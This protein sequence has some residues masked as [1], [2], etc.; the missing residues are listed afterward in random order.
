MRALIFAAGRGERLRPY[1]D[2]LAKP[3]I[4]FLNIPI[5]AFPLFYLEQAGLQEL[6]VNTHHLPETVEQTLKNLVPKKVSLKFSHETPLIL[7]SGGGLAQA[8]RQFAS[9]TKEI[10]VANGDAVALF[11]DVKILERLLELHRESQALATL[12]VCPF[13]PAVEQ[14]GGVYV[15]GQGQVTT[16][17]KKTLLLA[18]SNPWHFS[19]YMVVSREVGQELSTTPSNLLYDFLLPQIQA[20]HKVMALCQRELHWFETGNLD[21]YLN[22]TH[23]CLKLLAQTGWATET[24]KKI[25]DRFSPGWIA[26]FSTSPL[27][28]VPPANRGGGTKIEDFAVVGEKVQLGHQVQLTQAVIVNSA[29]VA[30][31]THVQRTLV[32]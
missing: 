14:F 25:L 31:G 5:V 19:G 7:G 20:G 18:D 21:D 12:L 16:F 8:V 17:S 24:L 6:V 22:A 23:S 32:I 9:S 2:K 4:P 29:E 1:T 13:P 28:L 26:N 30:N 10:F 3:T 15:N 11:P 27:A